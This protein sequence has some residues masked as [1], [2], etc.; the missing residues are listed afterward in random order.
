MGKAPF[1]LRSQG[2][3]FKMM[4]SSSPLR[5]GKYTG[6]SKAEVRAS[7]LANNKIHNKAS[8]IDRQSMNS[9]IKLWQLQN[10]EIASGPKSDVNPE[11]R[12]K[13]VVEPV[14]KE[15]GFVATKGNIKI[16]SGSKY[17][18]TLTDEQLET[19]KIRQS[20]VSRADR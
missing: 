18:A 17:D 3:S 4:G 1:K 8:D 13:V 5:D 11:I 7:V 16:G 10:R 14:E 9:E 2:S 12:K 6:M 19:Q 20:K 15:T